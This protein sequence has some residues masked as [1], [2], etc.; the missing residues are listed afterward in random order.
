MKLKALAILPAVALLTGC[1]LG[2]SDQTTKDLEQ[3]CELVRA[4]VDTDRFIPDRAVEFFAKA[5]RTNSEYLPLIKAAR[6]G[7]LELNSPSLNFQ[8][9]SEIIQARSFILGYCLPNPA[10]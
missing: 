7:Q 5:A 3:A 6:L 2:G 1:S 10:E 9:D 4:R 8:L